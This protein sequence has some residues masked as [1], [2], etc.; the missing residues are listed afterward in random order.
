MKKLLSILTILIIGLILSACGSSEDETNTSSSTEASESDGPVE[1]KLG[2]GYAT[3][4]NLW[5][6]KV[7]SDLA[8]NYG[9][10]YTLELQQFRAN[11]DRLNAYRA[12]QIHG[13]TLGQG[14]SIM[15]KAQGV[16]MKVIAN[17]AKESPDDGFNSAFLA[18]ADSDI[19]SAKDLKGKTV[20]V[21]DFKSPTD[22]WAR[23]AIREAG[24]DPDKDVEYA[25]LPIPAMQEAIE[26]GKIDVGMFPQP[27]YD[28]A[29]NSG[30][31]KTIF[32]SKDG[33][34]IEE[35]FL[36]L[37]M[38][39]KFVEEN[40]EAVQ[41]LVSDLQTMTEYYVNNPEEARQKLLDAEFVLAD[42]EVYLQMEDYARA[43]D[44]SFNREGW[45]VVQDILLK[46][47]WIEEEVDL[48]T[49]IDESF[50]SGDE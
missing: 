28:M 46:E 6:M 1:I 32:T 16:D 50:I 21:V 33:V 42:P 15:S 20:G 34:P 43:I 29:E 31:L 37:F 49:L 17:I 39:P 5:L 24:L 41:A 35:D 4:E 23:S 48:D 11:A 30:E 2:V 38:E 26:S 12:G 8:P 3:E 27:F 19:E 40:E 13:G 14:A 22:M 45:D 47:E 44:G 7:A 25:V 18:S 36:N 10:K 9:E